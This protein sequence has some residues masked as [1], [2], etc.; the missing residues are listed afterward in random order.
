MSAKGIPTREMRPLREVTCVV[1][2]LRGPE[3]F[4]ACGHYEPMR[5]PNKPAPKRARCSTCAPVLP[6]EDMPR[7]PDP[8][9]L[10][11]RRGRHGR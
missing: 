4:L 10:V 8:M 5:Y 2:S 11:K 6:V 3:L 9:A 1:G 7:G